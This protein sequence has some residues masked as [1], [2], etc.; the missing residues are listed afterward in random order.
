APPVAADT[1]GAQAT[2][3]VWGGAPATFGAPIVPSALR[4][5]ALALLMALTGLLGFATS[6][7]P[8]PQGGATA[9]A[10][11]R[12]T[13]L[14]LSFGAA[15]MLAL[16]FVAWLLHASSRHTLGGGET[17]APLRS[18]VAPRGEW[19]GGLAGPPRVA[20]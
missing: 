14:W 10:R 15:A 8:P 5:V 16:H 7:A 9:F 2:E 19:R 4:G 11:A 17:A 20:P 1:A 6:S 3:P 13:T 18:G 12:R